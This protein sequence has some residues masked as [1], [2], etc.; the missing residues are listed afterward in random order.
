[1]KDAPCTTARRILLFYRQRNPNAV[2]VDPR[3]R[4]GSLAKAA[5]FTHFLFANFPCGDCS[6]FSGNHLLSNWP[7]ALVPDYDEGDLFHNSALVSELRRS[8]H[9]GQPRR[10][11][12]RE[13]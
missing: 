2:T 7:E 5:G 8:S 11:G 12:I 9:A 4:L 10:C 6:G 1:M 13:Q 3:E